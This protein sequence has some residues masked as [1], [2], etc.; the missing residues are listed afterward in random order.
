MQGECREN[1]KL[2]V[3][4]AESCLPVR[5]SLHCACDKVL[6]VI[7]C[8]HS[9]SELVCRVKYGNSLPDIPFDPK[10]IAYPFE[11]SLK[12]VGDERAYFSSLLISNKIK[13][14]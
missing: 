4:V 10:F 7:S 2:H 1:R 3:T 6:D 11:V 13:I 14:P 12:S 8:L 5:L 9:R